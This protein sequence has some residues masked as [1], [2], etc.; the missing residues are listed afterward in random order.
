MVRTTR[1]SFI[2]IV[3]ALG[4]WLRPEG[5]CAASAQGPLLDRLKADWAMPPRSCRPHT[6]WW[7]PGNAVTAEGISWQL[8]Q[9][10]RQGMG[11]VEI[12]SCWRWYEKGTIPYLS[13]EWKQM[14]RHAIREAA[15]RDMEVALTFGPGWSFGGFWV[16]PEDRSKVL[17]CA[18]LDVQ[19][20]ARF[21][22]RLPQYQPGLKQKS[23]APSAELDWL[24]PDH[25]RVIAA[26]AAQ[27]SGD[28]LDGKTL[29]DLT[30]LVEGDRLQWE[31]PEG[32]WRIMAFR[33]LYTG[34][35]N[36]AQNYLPR[37][38]VVDHLNKAAME[39]YCDFLI[40]EFVE[41]FGDELGKTV[42]SFF[43]DSFEIHPLPNTLLWSSD[44]LGL[45]RRYKGYDLTP[46]LPAIWFD[47][48]E[49]TPRVR[50]DVN[51]FLHWLG[52][53]T[54][55]RTFI[56][57]AASRGVQARIQPHYR[58]TEEIIQGAGM[59]P[60]PE[61]EVTT[62]RFA[63]IA[64]PRKSTAAGAHFY[65]RPI[66]SAEA[67]TFI[68]PERYRTTLQDMK[69]ATDAFLRDGVT[70]FYNHGYVYSPEIAV[71]PSR[72]VPWA[73][74]ISHWNTWWPYYHHLT[75]YISRCCYLLRQGKPVAD[76]LLYSPQATVWTQRVLF[77]SERRIMPYGNVPLTLIAN[78]YDYEPIN[79]DLVQNHAS[80][81]N[82][83][84]KVRDLRF[85][86]L[87]LPAITAL[88]LKTLEVMKQFVEGG[89]ILI[90]LE[91]LPRF[92]V[93]LKAYPGE[94][95]RVQEL[96][97]ELFGPQGGGRE[98]NSGGR[99]Y[100]L[101][102]YKIVQPEFSPQEQP[103]QPPPPLDAAQK[104]LLEILRRHRAPDLA[105]AG[106]QQSEGI[107]FL[108]R[109]VGEFE[110]YFVSNLA[111]KPSQT[112]LLFRVRE[113]WPAR[114]DPYTGEITAV[115]GFRVRTEGI[116]IPLKFEPWQS[117]ILV[118]SPG[119]EPW[120]AVE[121]SLD[122]LERVEEAEVIGLTSSPGSC[123][124]RIQRGRTVREGAATAGSVPPPIPVA[125]RWKMTV[126]GVRFARKELILD[127]L[128]SWGEREELRFFSGTGTY[129]L[130]VDL[131]AAYAAPD[132][133]VV[134]ELGR[135][136]DV[137]EVFWNDRPA[138]V[139]WTEPYRVNV[140][141]YL[142]PGINRLRVLVTNTLIHHIAG[143]HEPPPV[144]AELIPH[145][146]QE[147]TEYRQARDAFYKRD[148][149]FRPLPP[150]GLIG[151]VRLVATRRV[152]VP[153]HPARTI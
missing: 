53:E 138:G 61:T 121:T 145:Y 126:E 103:W 67:Y 12:M 64:D 20:P 21:A 28:R 66:V 9:M 27:H 45:F 39:R 104:Q 57:T 84:L 40:Q 100:F 58:F 37:N 42:D 6:R 51:Q 87:I 111:P 128:G 69:I 1:R 72:D 35:Q 24:P 101:A 55:F 30:H 127:Q 116:E 118:F 133:E 60:R 78:G 81:V 106:Y 10:Y 135:V 22:D 94:D 65:G 150:S 26:V 31:V 71:A 62:A 73:N 105:L 93:G 80:V 120:H 151:P 83:E 134:L 153:V 136:G 86:F 19:G 147:F 146:G 18:W 123:S 5:A 79:D 15:K 97:G 129:E 112:P 77:G 131:P 46:Y 132:L 88:P 8:E 50:Y 33:L 99:S 140:T 115:P 49:L 141:K 98:F 90:A 96:V 102:A 149:L 29:K 47:I 76:V 82:G 41:A 89:G 16:P 43:C 52:L 92:S 74:R 85:R 17:A 139:C 137:A 124:V 70:Q 107:A 125:G 48:G 113:K 38:W 63:T 23:E 3:S 13:P 117:T 144:P 95:R 109:E 59:T 25:N 143:L 142:R 108:H 148:R 34:Q 56:E 32:A 119:D 91:K 54:A 7:W 11:G 75:A 14:V 44:T 2:G 114:W 130:E 110:V 68:H 122:Q 4:R 152:R 36:Q